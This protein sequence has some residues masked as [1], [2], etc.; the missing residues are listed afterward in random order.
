MFRFFGHFT[1]SVVVSSLVVVIGSSA[2]AE[3]TDQALPG[4]LTAV[5]LERLLNFDLSVTLSSRKEEPLSHAA[6]AI[7]VITQEDIRRSGVTHVAEALRLVPGV[8]VARVSSNRWAISIRGFNQIFSNKL[9]VLVDG[10]SIFSPTTNG[11]YWEANELLLE[12]IDRI[13]VVRGPGAALW[14]ANAVNGVINII[15]KAPKET[16][17]WLVSAGAGTLERDFAS[18]RYGGSLSDATDYRLYGVYHSRV[19]NELHDGGDADDDWLSGAGGMRLDSDFDSANH[20]SFLADVQRQ[21]DTLSPTVPALVPPYSDSETFRGNTQWSGIRS[22][23]EWGHDFSDTSRLKSILSYQRKERSSSLVSFNYDTVNLDVQHQISFGKRHQ[24]VYGGYARYFTNDSEG[25]SGQEVEPESRDTYLWSGF[26]HDEIALVPDTLRLVVGAKFEHNDSTGLETMPNI[27]FVYT[28]A[29]SLT[30]WTAVS[31]AVAPP[32][33]FFEDTRI[34]VQAFPLP[35]API[36]GLVT[37]VG[38][39]NLESEDLIA[40]E[41]GARYEVSS[42]LSVD[43]A[44]FYNSYDHIFSAEP[45]NPTVAFSSLGLGG[46]VLEIPLTLAN[47]LQ[48][49]SYGGEIA[50][51]WRPY[52]WLSFVGSYSYLR[53]DIDMGDSQDSANL[54]LIE[55][56][57][58]RHQ[59]NLRTSI[60]LPSDMRADAMLRYVD[61]LSWGDVP[62]Y[63]E[64]D[65]GLT[66]QATKSIDVG[67][68]GQNLLHAD[69]QEFLPNLFALPATDIGRGALAR[70]RWTF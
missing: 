25:S 34:P 69:H 42:A 38:N 36:P 13:E 14:G 40:Y 5:G 45:G 49:S 44:F 50:A 56:G 32:A 67:V 31:R 60:R 52:D 1:L 66:W 12:D 10:V 48:G 29:R 57:A 22:A 24:F 11:V 30:L 59:A 41:I 35:D 3:N 8:N 43:T 61:H 20:I 70:V 2:V 19:S 17:G 68:F 63:V 4:D 23:L 55:G 33:L 16:K 53:V 21:W 47:Q 27:R 64:L 46:P 7:S 37:V 26:L 15:S 39:R 62:S 28:P 58:P 9:L 65:L 54:A 6:S 51:E 18:A